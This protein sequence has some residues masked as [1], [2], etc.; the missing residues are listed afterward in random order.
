MIRRLVEWLL[1][2]LGIKR[3]VRKPT[4]EC[5]LDVLPAVYAATVIIRVVKQF[6][7]FPPLPQYRRI[8]YSLKRSLRRTRMVVVGY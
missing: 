8:L 4:L 5:L 6:G 1:D 2:V 3:R 7:P